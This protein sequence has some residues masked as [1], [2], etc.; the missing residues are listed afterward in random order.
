MVRINLT[1]TDAYPKSY[2]QPCIIATKSSS[3][4]TGNWVLGVAVDDDRF[5]VVLLVPRSE[6]LL[7]P[8]C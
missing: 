5:S 8:R 6:E 7:D 3:Q 1:S 4:L 2:Q